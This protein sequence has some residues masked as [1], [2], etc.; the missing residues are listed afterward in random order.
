MNKLEGLKKV[1]DDAYEWKCA[2]GHARSPGFSEYT[3]A[4]DAFYAAKA[5][6]EVAVKEVK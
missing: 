4:A 3:A 2:I 5:A 1:M 6:Y